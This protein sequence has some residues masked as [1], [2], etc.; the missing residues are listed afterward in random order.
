MDEPVL[1]YVNGQRAFFTTQPLESQWGDDW[2]DAPYEHNAGSPYA[3][4]WIDKRDKKPLWEIHSVL[5]CSELVTPDYEAWN[6]PYSVQDINA[7]NIPWLREADDTSAGEH[8]RIYAGCTLT[9]F[10]RLI[11]QACGCVSEHVEIEG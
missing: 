9:D 5:F 7:G 8:I 3:P 4:S 6:S 11:V 10:R 2:N 1:C